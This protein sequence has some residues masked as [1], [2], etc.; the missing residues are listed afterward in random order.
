MSEQKT[1]VA[2]EATP[3]PPQ[4]QDPRP[5]TKPASGPKRVSVYAPCEHTVFDAPFLDTAQLFDRVGGNTGNLAF[6][7]GVMRA[8]GGGVPFFRWGAD[9]AAVK[10]ACDV[11]VMP[12]ANQVGM[13]CD[14]GNNATHLEK[15]DVGLVALGLGAQANS[16]DE[17]VEAPEGTWRWLKVIADHSVAGAPNIGVRGEYTRRQLE[18]N[19]LGD[20]VV[21]LGCPSLFISPFPDLGQRIAKR[22]EERPI[23]RVAVASGQ[24]YWPQLRFIERQLVRLATETGGAYICQHPIHMLQLARNEGQR[25]DPKDAEGLR[26]YLMPNA[27]LRA[28]SDWASR[29]AVAFVNILAWMDF[30]RRYDFVVGPRIHGVALAMQAGVPGL[31]IAHDSRTIELCEAMKIPYVQPKDLK[32][33]ISVDYLKKIFRFDASAFDQNR[34]ERAD[35]MRLISRLSNFLL[36]HSFRR[37][38]Q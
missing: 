27:D 14:M 18:K 37:N 32:D 16:F 4:A 6:V 38:P 7:Y 15:M 20:N 19:G 33:E 29:Y 24:R 3:P 8:L 31:C 2:E 30:V 5:E 25:M 23:R 34:A 12:C 11:A 21:V 10:T 35:A 1:P 26:E 28:L 17:D 13:H 36:S 22:L 9:P